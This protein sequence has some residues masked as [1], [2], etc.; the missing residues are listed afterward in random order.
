MESI[1]TTIKKLL[2]YD[3]DYTQFDPDII[4]YINMALLS[5]NQ[6]GVGPA[7]GFTISDKNK[8][9][10]DFI[11]DREDIDAVKT[12]IYLKVRLIFDPPSNSYLVDLIKHEIDELEWRL[13]SQVD[14][15]PVITTIVEGGT[16][17]G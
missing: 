13:N 16:A 7:Q 1:L 17:D 5:A 11:G 10:S 9:W 4:I 12:Y 14:P 15:L 3:E 2:G 8:T 6:I